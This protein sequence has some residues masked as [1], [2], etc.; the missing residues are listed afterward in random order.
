MGSEQR[1]SR[2]EFVWK[3][4]SDCKDE[5]VMLGLREEYEEDEPRSPCVDPTFSPASP[6]PS[7][8]VLSYA[9]S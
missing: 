8:S 7:G 6:S 9:E 1:R 2:A 5:V 3:A 4:A